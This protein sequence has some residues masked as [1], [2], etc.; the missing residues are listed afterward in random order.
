ML[1]PEV[2]KLIE[3][4][5]SKYLLVTAAA[6]RARQLKDNAP[7]TIENTAAHKEVGKALEE[8]AR[9]TI[10]LEEKKAEEPDK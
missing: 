6:K 4:V 7:L 3:K 10:T 1:I 2:D 9:G 8:I 5:G